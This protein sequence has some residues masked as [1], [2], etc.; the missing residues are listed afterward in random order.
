[1]TINLSG[2]DDNATLSLVKASL[3]D[4]EIAGAENQEDEWPNDGSPTFPLID[5]LD[6]APGQTF[7]EAFH[8]A[9]GRKISNIGCVLAVSSDEEKEVM[10]SITPLRDGIAIFVADFTPPVS[11]PVPSAP[12]PGPKKED[13]NDDSKILIPGIVV[14]IVLGSAAIIL[15]VTLYVKPRQGGAGE[16]E[17]GEAAIELQNG[18]GGPGG[19]NLNNGQS[20]NT[21]NGSVAAG[22]SS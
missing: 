18:S 12:Q 19:T 15:G 7:A 10:E 11:S 22:P 16:D 8:N 14:C 5:S 9:T 2:L 21:T 17:G 4:C 6:V 3:S 20:A 1:M 13:S